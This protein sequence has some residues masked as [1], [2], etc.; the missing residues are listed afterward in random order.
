VSLAPA[1]D[2]AWQGRFDHAKQRLRAGEFAKASALFGKLARTASSTADRRLVEELALLSI[3]WEERGLTF[4]RRADLGESSLSARARDERTTDEISVLYT[5]SVLYGLASGG[6][7]ATLTE[8]ENLAG[9]I[10][11]SLALG[12]ASAGTV[13]LLD[14]FDSFGY[15]VPHSIVSGM[16][17]GLE[18]GLL[19]TLWNQASVDREDEWGMKALSTVIWASTTVGAVTG[20]VLGSQIGTTPGRASFVSSSATWTG[21]VIGLATAAL[22]PD[23]E[24]TD[25]RA[26]LAA[27]ISLNAVAVAGILAASPVSPTV[28]RVRFIDLGGL[29]GGLLVGGIYLSAANEDIDAQALMGSLALGIPAGLTATWFLTAGME[30]DRPEQ[31]SPKRSPVV[32]LEPTVLPVRDGALVGVAGVLW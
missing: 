23:D 20:G 18:E 25:D 17:I 24:A 8:P 19:W 22:S 10:L 2:P 31:E 15:G 7:L 26:L 5:N 13:A 9:F 29:A 16:Y 28:A 14:H 12:G 32:E 27:A 30:E 4:V 1:R 11:P 21:G 3:Y 6:W